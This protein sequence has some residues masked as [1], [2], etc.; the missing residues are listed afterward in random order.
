MKGTK[1]TFKNIIYKK[2][3]L[4]Q[5]LK[6]NNSKPITLETFAQSNKN[7]KLKNQHK[8]KSMSEKKKTIYEAKELLSKSIEIDYLNF[9]QMI[10]DDKYFG[11]SNSFSR[12]ELEYKKRIN[13]RYEDCD[14]SLNSI[15]IENEIKNKKI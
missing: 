3:K 14:S 9:S 13:N 10:I 5:A 6:Q 12:L 15:E 1:K 4:K 8:N 7:L 2:N 11:L